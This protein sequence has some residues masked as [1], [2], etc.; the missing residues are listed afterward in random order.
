MPDEGVDGVGGGV[1]CGK[2]G[3]GVAF[4]GDES[5]V[6]LVFCTCGDPLAECL[7]LRCSELFVGFWRGHDLVWVGA[8]DALDERAGVRLAG[9]DG[10]FSRFCWGEGGFGKIEAKSAFE[11]FAIGSMAR[12]AV[13]GEDGTDLEV[14]VGFR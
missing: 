13:V 6:R 1:G 14:V 10:A 3:R 11:I 9:N 7:D 2:G 8:E 4:W 5:P 12:E